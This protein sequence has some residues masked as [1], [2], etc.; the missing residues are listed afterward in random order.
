MKFEL[1]RIGVWSAIKVSFFIWGM[2]GFIGGIYMA[3]MMPVLIN[4]M[5]SLGTM[6]PDMQDIGPFA[7]FFLPI[8]YS[9]MAAVF[10]TVLTA[11]LTGFFNL[12][13]RLLG[14]IELDLES[15]TIQPLDL[16]V[17][18]SEPIQRGEDISD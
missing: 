12:I 18:E 7:L 10:G 5:G 14:G 6:P 3:L 9:L 11:I 2:L 13:C 16:P 17:S 1:K 8:M 15:E 4:M